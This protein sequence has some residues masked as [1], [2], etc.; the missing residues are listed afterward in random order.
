M[1][2]KPSIVIEQATV[3]PN[4]TTDLYFECTSV[5]SHL[6]AVAT[7]TTDED[8]LRQLQE[9]GLPVYRMPHPPA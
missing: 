7:M 6:G 3:R 8:F 5:R 1:A 2:E 4:G 9:R